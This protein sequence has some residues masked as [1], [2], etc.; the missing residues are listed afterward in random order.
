MQRRLVLVGTALSLALGCTTP[1]AGNFARHAEVVDQML[2]KDAVERLVTLYPPA[3]TRLALGQDLSDPF[4]VA[5]VQGLRTAGYAIREG[6]APETDEPAEES[7]E[8][9]SSAEVPL[10]YLVDGAGEVSRLTV[11]VGSTELHRA[12]S[13]SGV[14]QGSWSVRTRE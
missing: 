7:A 12:Y 1:G 3:R 2:A 11:V 14:Q 13:Y 4:G 10:S 5:F 6:A 8:D 9:S